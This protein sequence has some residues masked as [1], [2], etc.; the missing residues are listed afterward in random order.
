MMYTN[1]NNKI[2][3][4]FNIEGIR[5]LRISRLFFCC[6]CSAKNQWAGLM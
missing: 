1:Q 6:I 5:N 3:F 4:M 2:T